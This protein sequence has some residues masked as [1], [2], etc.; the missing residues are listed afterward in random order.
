MLPNP[1][2]A[3]AMSKDLAWRIQPG[4]SDHE[5]NEFGNNVLHGSTDIQAVVVTNK[6]VVV[7][8]VA[9]VLKT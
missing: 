7:V 8:V 4:C 9:V 6:V 2:V 1:I 3:A 5:G